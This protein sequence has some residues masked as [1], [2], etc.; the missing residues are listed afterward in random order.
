[1]H[2]AHFSLLGLH[3]RQTAGCLLQLVLTKLTGFHTNVCQVLE[4]LCKF[5][6]AAAH[7]ATSGQLFPVSRDTE[8]QKSQ[9]RLTSCWVQTWGRTYSLSGWRSPGTGCPGRLWSLLLW[10]YSKPTWTRS[11]AACCRWPCFGSGVGL[12]DPQSSLRTTTIV[13]FLDTLRGAN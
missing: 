6:W 11:Y 12:D 9:I 7:S 13:W 8:E 2:Q 5:G 4:A 1:M 10:T 3:L